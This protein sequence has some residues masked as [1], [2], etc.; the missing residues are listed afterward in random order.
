MIRLSLWLP[1]ELIVVHESGGPAGGG[2]V[3]S[4]CTVHLQHM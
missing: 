3:K 1:L 2:A 4:V